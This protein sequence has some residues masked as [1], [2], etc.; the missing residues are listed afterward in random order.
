MPAGELGAD[1]AASY[2]L[3]LRRCINPNKY[4]NKYKQLLTFTE[5]E[6]ETGTVFLDSQQ[7]RGYWIPQ[8]NTYET[9]SKTA[10]PATPKPGIFNQLQAKQE[11]IQYT[12]PLMNPPTPLETHYHYHH[13]TKTNNNRKNLI[14]KWR[15][16]KHLPFIFYEFPYMCE[17]SSWPALALWMSGRHHNSTIGSFVMD[18]TTTGGDCWGIVPHLLDMGVCTSW[19]PGLFITGISDLSEHNQLMMWRR[20]DCVRL[21]IWVRVGRYRVVDELDAAIYFEERRGRGGRRRSLER[22]GIRCCVCRW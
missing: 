22:R 15:I 13:Q 3:S 21:L 10:A 1:A 8:V 19:D 20:A 5:T 2:L 11:A 14:Y 9:I 17:L 7:P 6:I 16:E 18:G 4:K 12:A